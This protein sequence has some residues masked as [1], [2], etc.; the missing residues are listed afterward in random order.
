MAAL[1][2]F[3][4]LQRNISNRFPKMYRNV[5]IS[6][7]TQATTKAAILVELGAP[8]QLSYDNFEVNAWE[9]RKRYDPA[10]SKHLR[11]GK[12]FFIAQMLHNGAEIFTNIHHVNDPNVDIKYSIQHMGKV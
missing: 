3:S 2:R 9:V 12:S 11:P 1:N 5:L 6:D 7:H 8:V 10:K 4:H